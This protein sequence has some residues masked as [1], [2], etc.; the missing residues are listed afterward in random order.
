M[1]LMVKV[2]IFM[3][4]FKIFKDYYEYVL[5]SVNCYF[6]LKYLDLRKELYFYLKKKRVCRVSLKMV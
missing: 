3:Y 6:E 5:R 2:I 4:Y 1:N